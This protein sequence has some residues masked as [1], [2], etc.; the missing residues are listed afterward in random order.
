M[1]HTTELHFEQTTLYFP[2]DHFLLWVVGWCSVHRFW[3]ARASCNEQAS[4]RFALRSKGSS[5][6]VTLVRH[7]FAAEYMSRTE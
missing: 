1:S 4:S 6:Q 5:H 2:A 7:D 3:Q